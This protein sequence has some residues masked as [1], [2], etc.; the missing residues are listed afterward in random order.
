[1]GKTH[2]FGI[3]GAGLIGD[4]HAKVIGKL[5]NA[6]LVGVFDQIPERT[7]D[8]ARKLGVKAFATLEELLSAR[9]IDI[10]TVGTPSGCHLNPAVEAARH[11]KHA[12]C[13]KPMEI[14]LARIDAMIAA[15]QAAGTTLGGIFNM[16]YTPLHRHLKATVSAGKLGQIVH[17]GGYVPWYR[18]PEYYS[19][20]G[21]RGS[22][23]FDGGGALMNQ[24]IHVVD[25]LQW[26][27]GKPVR[28]V[29]ASVAHTAHRTIEVEDTAAAVLEFEGGTLGT[30]YATTG[31]WPGLP[32]R[33]E[34]GGTTGSVISTADG[35]EV[36]RLAGEP[37]AEAAAFAAFGAKAQGGGAA[38]P[39]G[40]PHENH[41]ANFAAFLDALDSGRRPEVDGPE[42]RK[43]VEIILAAYESARTGLPVDIKR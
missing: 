7:A 2:R 32:E 24:G 10:V 25:M 4:L 12:L 26:L 37:D 3:V 5:P 9:E 15:H 38:N 40:I 8:F 41:A 22:W 21:W 23:Q 42:A 43:A 18:A 30:L 33:I 34:V 6:E 35:L 29:M 14:T 31:M 1:M 16:R 28:R 19:R 17:V 13:E 39:G 36:F 11:G 27:V 20:G